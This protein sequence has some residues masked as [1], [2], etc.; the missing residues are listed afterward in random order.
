[1]VIYANSALARISADTLISLRR[2]GLSVKASPTF[3]FT[4]WG[5]L[6]FLSVVEMS[7]QDEERKMIKDDNI[8]LAR[9]ALACPVPP[10][11]L[12][13]FLQRSTSKLIW[14]ISLTQYSPC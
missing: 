7:E 1:M 3:A 12:R 11:L 9:A 10:L 8:E 4:L 5:V 2:C 6:R 14:H 13:M